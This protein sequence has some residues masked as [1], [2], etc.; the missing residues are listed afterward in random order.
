MAT[1]PIS[2]VTEFPDVLIK[3]LISIYARNV[4]NRHAIFTDKLKR[5][6]TNFKSSTLFFYAIL[7]IATNSINLK[8]IRRVQA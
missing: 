5:F 3:R 2:F 6:V 7:Q 8:N 1:F 4:C